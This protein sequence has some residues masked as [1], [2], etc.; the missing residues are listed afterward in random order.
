M[1]RRRTRSLDQEVTLNAEANPSR[2]TALMVVAALVVAW[3]IAGAVGAADTPYSGFFTDGNNTVTQV[4]DASPAQMAGL[5]TGDVISSTGVIA[6][7]DVRAAT[8]RARA[9]IA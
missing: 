5:Q 6:V 4:L 7:S 1:D 8:D 2:S 9:S 3:G